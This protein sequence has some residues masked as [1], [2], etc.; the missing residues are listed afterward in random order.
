MAQ[1][2]MTS[3]DIYKLN[4]GAVTEETIGGVNYKVMWP[5]APDGTNDVYG[6]LITTNGQL[7]LIRNNKGSKS[8]SITNY[9]ANTI[10][11]WVTGS[12]TTQTKTVSYSNYSERAGTVVLLN[13]Y[14]A[15]TYKG[16]VKMNVNSQGAKDLYLNGQITSATNYDIPKGVYVTYF[17][18]TKYYMRTDG[19]LP[20]PQIEQMESDVAAL[21]S[22]L[23]DV[24][25]FSGTTS[26]NGN[27]TLPNEYKVN[28]CNI[29]F[30][31][32][33]GEYRETPVYGFP[34]YISN[35][36]WGFHFINDNATPSVY[37]NSNVTVKF[38]VIPF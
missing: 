8:T 37:G 4:W 11:G 34:R 7:G 18:G 27:L 29:I 19:K 17:D 24:K 2:F 36:N 33:Y 30:I 35:G 26:A 23:K 16:L 6:L 32:A 15:N 14:N 12:S 5:I 3:I 10:A 25:T 22:N 1:Q 13:W 9:N 38:L 28:N 31:E 20:I 21:N